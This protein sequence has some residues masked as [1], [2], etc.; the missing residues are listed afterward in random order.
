MTKRIYIA[1]VLLLAVPALNFAQQPQNSMTITVK[2]VSFKMIRVQGGTFTMGATSEQRSYAYNWELP[3]HR[4]TLSTYYIGE[5][6]VTQE[7]WTAVMDS[8]PSYFKGSKRPVEQVSWD[9]CQEFIRKLNQLTGKNFR[10]PTEAEWEFASRG[11]TKNMH[12]KY[13]GSN[14]IN[15][16]AWYTD[17]ASDMDNSS[18]DY[19]THVVKTKKPNELG[20]YDMSGNV[21]E[22][23]SDWYGKYT[24]A[25]LVNPQG[26]S[27]GSSRVLRGGSWNRIAGYSRSSLRFSHGPDYRRDNLGLRLVLV[28]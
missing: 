19:G 7:L 25:A 2:D 24:D 12:Y 11:G 16:V 28:L 18:P 23:C 20:I 10:L 3:A 27:S 8:T 22:W 6:E 5:T 15:A 1:L 17:N 21:W 14:D 26:A 13:S 4:V 9:D